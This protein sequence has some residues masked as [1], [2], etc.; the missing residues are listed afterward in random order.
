M[1]KSCE[2]VE[3]QSDGSV[4]VLARFSWRGGAVE[5]ELTGPQSENVVRNILGDG[6]WDPRAQA[7]LTLADGERFIDAAPRLISGDRIWVAAVQGAE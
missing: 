1:S 3:L 4:A 7:K 6:L 5:V 2:L